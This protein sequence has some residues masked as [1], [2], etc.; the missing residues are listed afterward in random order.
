MGGALEKLETK[1]GKPDHL[2]PREAPEGAERP[3]VQRIHLGACY[4]VEQRCDLC[5]LAGHEH[6]LQVENP[7]ELA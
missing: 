6:R 3:T 7:P 5:K 2:Q 4:Q 1:A